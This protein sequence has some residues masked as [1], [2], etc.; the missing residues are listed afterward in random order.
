MDTLRVSDDGNCSGEASLLAFDRCDDAGEFIVE[1]SGLKP[2][3]I[4]FGEGHEDVSP[5]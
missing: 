5:G 4:G 1:W 3:A 2:A